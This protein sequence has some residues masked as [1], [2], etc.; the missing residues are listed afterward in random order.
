VA[1]GAYGQ[2]NAPA[3]AQVNKPEPNIVCEE[4][5]YNFG[6][7]SNSETVEHVF[8]LKNSG[9]LSVEI[10]HVR[11][12]CGCTVAKLSEKIIRPGEQVELSSRLNLR[13]R[14]GKQRKRITV[15]SNDPDTPRMQLYLEGTAVA[16]MTAHPNRIFFGQLGTEQDASRTVNITPGKEPLHVKNVISTDKHFVP[17]LEVVEDGRNY[18]VHVRTKPP[19]PQG[20][21][22]GHVRVSFV[23]DKPDI[24]IPIQ[25]S[26]QGPLAYAPQEIVLAKQGSR[27]VTRYVVI[28]PG[29]VKHFQIKEVQPPADDIQVKIHPI[30]G[31]GFRIELSNMVAGDEL[32]GSELKIMTDAAQMPEL[33]I[34]IKVLQPR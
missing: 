26:V 7:R 20:R 22:R 32:H 2:T 14:R 23:E 1:A 17:E 34:P 4:P 27:P 11:A 3:D 8:I 29:T 15:H 28:R 10:G 31:N 16:P 13:G 9:D 6:E 19:L 30:G 12:S 21:L 24:N 33:S 5:T 25:A 18:K